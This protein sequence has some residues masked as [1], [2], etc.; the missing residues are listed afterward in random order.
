MCVVHSFEKEDFLENVCILSCFVSLEAF[1]LTICVCLICI[2]KRMSSVHRLKA[3]ETEAYT[4]EEAERAAGMGSYK[5]PKHHGKVS[6]QPV[7]VDMD[8]AR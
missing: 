3:L 1:F 2:A 4:Q 6:T 5:Q 8:T 7:Q